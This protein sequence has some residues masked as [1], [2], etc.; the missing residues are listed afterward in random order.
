MLEFRARIGKR[1]AELGNQAS[2]FR[3]KAV[4][5]KRELSKFK[6]RSIRLHTS[7]FRF[8]TQLNLELIL[9]NCILNFR[10]FLGEVP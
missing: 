2:V 4:N 1:C 5:L 3:P 10:S 9:G 7:H 6:E 8:C